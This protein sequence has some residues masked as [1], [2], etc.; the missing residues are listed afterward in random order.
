MLSTL[1]VL[2][3]GALIRL[4]ESL[5]PMH[6]TNIGLSLETGIVSSDVQTIG[7]LLGGEDAAELWLLDLDSKLSAESLE[8]NRI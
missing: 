2:K 1:L 7:L 4:Q 8:L 3:P 6:H 5:N